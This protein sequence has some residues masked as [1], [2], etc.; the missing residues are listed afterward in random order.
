M[1]VS[2]TIRL[3]LVSDAFQSVTA[4]SACKSEFHRRGWRL[5]APSAPFL[6]LFPLPA[7]LDVIRVWRDLTILDHVLLAP[8]SFDTAALFSR[9]SSFASF[10]SFPRFSRAEENVQI[11]N[12]DFVIASIDRN[13]C[14]AF[15]INNRCER[16]MFEPMQET[17][18]KFCAPPTSMQLRRGLLT[19]LYR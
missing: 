19:I 6:R 4:R 10:L 11:S 15:P 3:I 7:S 13:N 1:P 5:H 12:R 9:L 18:M 14:N 17:N 2:S 16:T 8:G